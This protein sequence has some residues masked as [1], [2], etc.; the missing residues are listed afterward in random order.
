MDISLLVA[1]HLSAG[2]QPTF[3]PEEFDLAM[4]KADERRERWLERLAWIKLAM[5]ML[6][7]DPEP[8]TKPDMTMRMNQN[9][10]PAV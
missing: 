3:D 6:R 7:R 5:A 10:R 1:A 9:I 8:S 4:R 2:N